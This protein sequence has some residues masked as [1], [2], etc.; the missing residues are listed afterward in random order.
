M[1][2][3]IV[4]VDATG[5]HGC[6]RDVGDGEFV[7]GCELP[8]CTDCITR[9]YVRRLKRSGAMVAIA[10]IVHWPNTE[11]T[12]TDNLLTGVREGSFK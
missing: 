4:T 7:V 2:Q 6:M 8:H 10:Q 12:V 5:N 3:F 9:E 11:S 1:G